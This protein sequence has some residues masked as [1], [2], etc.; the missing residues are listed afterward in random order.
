MGKRTVK[1]TKHKP[2]TSN[3]FLEVPSYL[4]E[5][6]I[7]MTVELTQYNADQVE[8]KSV[9]LQSSIKDYIDDSKINWFNIVGISDGIKVN[10]ICRDCGLHGFDIRDLLSD[11]QIVKMVVYDKVTF[12]LLTAFC[13]GE[14]ENIN[15]TQIA[16]I[17]GDNYIISF[18]DS[19]KT[20][21]TDV[22]AAIKQNN[23]LIRKKTADFL[24]YILLNVV[25]SLNINA[26]LN[27]EDQL[28]RIE[29]QLIKQEPY[30]SQ[31]LHFLH[32]RRVD[33]ILMKRS[34]I[35]LREEYRNL[36]Q[37]DNGLIKGDNVIY[38]NHFDDRLR[39]ML[40][41]LETLHESLSS[42]LDLYYNNNNMKMN[43]IMKRLTLVSTIF[44]PLTFMVGVWGMNFKF[45]PELEWEYGYIAAWIILALVAIFSGYFLKKKRWF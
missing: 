32:I 26:I 20:I 44:I 16:F 43:E 7:P 25:N 35:S 42:L 37:N 40:G 19:P 28:T 17:V 11:Q 36:Q 45:M 14:D 38:F 41:N 3:H 39:T 1:K 8:I 34:I 6:N 13:L 33:Y 12:I 24:L 4:G 23:L 31:L 18:Q 9:D 5:Q 27:V 2:S 22:Q 15:S 30:T 21:F 29:D 10:K